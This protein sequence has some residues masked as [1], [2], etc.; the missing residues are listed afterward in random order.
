VARKLID[1]IDKLGHQGKIEIKSDQEPAMLELVKEVKRL[2]EAE[3]LIANS[4]VYDSQSNGTAE[5]AVQ[6][7]EGMTRTHKLALE[8]KLGRKIPSTHPIMAWLI[9]YVVDVLNKFTVGDD[10][11]TPY[12]RARGK[13]FRG[14]T[15]AFGRKVYHMSP[16]KHQGG[17]MQSRWSEGIVLGKKAPSDE[18]IIF[19]VQ[20]KIVKA[21]SI[22]LM[23]EA[24]SWDGDLVAKI[25][26][27]PCKIKPEEEA[28]VVDGP[29]FEV[30]QEEPQ[31]KEEPVMQEAIP[32]DFYV[33]AHHVEKYGYTKQC[34]RC[35]VM[36]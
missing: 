29:K 4:K 17:S 21:R 33:K 6:T 32:R 9:E 19:D 22:K 30:R 34:P 13:K 11:R 8:R 15:F 35:R 18:N 31:D 27:T 5:R 1:D 7:V 20:G 36:L 28:E 12:E 3:T 24:D 10:G 2:R 14:E 25:Q 16:G 23:P 26:S